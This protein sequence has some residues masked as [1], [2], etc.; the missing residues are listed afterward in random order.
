M[1]D[2]D[3]DRPHKTP[4]RRASAL[5]A[6]LLMGVLVAGCA[7]ASQEPAAERADILEEA[8][9]NCDCTKE[10]EQETQ[11]DEPENK[12]A[13]AEPRAITSEE[14]TFKSKGVELAGVV[15]RPREVSEPL[16]AVVM[17]H[18]AGPMDRRGLFGGSLG[19]D[20]PVEVAV[21]EELAEN[22][23]QNGYVV[24]RFDKRTCV[25]GG[26][27]WCTYPR[28]YVE[29]HR[30]ELVSA[31]MADAKAAA[32]TLRGRDDVDPNRMIILGHGQG[33]EIALAVAKDVDASGLV[34]LAPSPYP[35]DKVVLHQTETSRTHLQAQRKAEGNTTM[36]TLLQEQIDALNASY[37]K[38]QDG[39]EKLRADELD[40]DNV[41]GAPEK[42]WTGLFELHD[43]AMA[44]LKNSKV[45]V[46]AVFGEHDLNLPG[47]SAAVFQEKLGRSSRSEVMHLAELTH[48]MVALDGAEDAETTQV[49]EDVHQAI[50]H[51]LNQL[52]KAPASVPEP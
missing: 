47:D 11:E 40:D 45:P 42:T 34:L 28:E 43:R 38:Q 29:D 13:S 50:L 4:L 20:L 6:V 31:L 22:L 36:G 46:L 2:V 37:Q 30:Q 24:L 39:F 48:P 41:L 12:R 17:L 51:F 16:P 5:C 7:T 14:I 35:V 23:A 27:P 8:T 18:D 44:G 15:D 10:K 32:V 9:R 25:D 49:S 1:I 3:Q 19:L 26:P 33:A 21:Y 52:D